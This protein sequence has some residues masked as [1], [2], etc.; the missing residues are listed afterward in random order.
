MC[1]VAFNVLPNSPFVL[2]TLTRFDTVGMFDR[3]ASKC[4]FA[5]SAFLYRTGPYGSIFNSLP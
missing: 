4:Y 2:Y 3:L 1:A 5:A